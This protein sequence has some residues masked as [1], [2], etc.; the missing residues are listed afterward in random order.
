MEARWPS[1]AG[2]LAGQLA[3]TLELHRWPGIILPVRAT[4]FSLGPTPELERAGFRF[5]DRG[6]HTSRTIMLAELS[7]LL[8]VCPAG[9]SREDQSKAIVERNALG[10]GTVATR[11]LTDQRLGEL[12]GLDP[13]LLLFRVVRRLWSVDA[14]GRPRI[15]LLAALSRDPLLRATAPF[16]LS[17]LP[18]QELVRADF[19]RELRKAVGSRLNDSTLDKV[20]RNT[21]SSWAQSGHLEGRVRKVRT[22]VEPTVGAVALALWL[23]SLEGLAGDQLLSCRWI[24]VL[25]SAGPE[26]IPIVVKARQLG[27]LH[28][29]IGGGIVEIDVRQLPAGAVEE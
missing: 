13:R 20:A 14:P 17:L 12:Y 27:L 22:R 28:A 9:A 8:A 29:R 24:R 1:F 4:D 11:R 25:D 19:L 2:K 6:T 5:G 15:A 23:G 21:A 16:V 18:G 7:E 10:K 26:L 3:W